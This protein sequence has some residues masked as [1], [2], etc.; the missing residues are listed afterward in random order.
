MTSCVNSLRHWWQTCRGKGGRGAGAAGGNRGEDNE[1]KGIVYCV[2]GQG[3]G[4]A[5]VTGGERGKVR[6]YYAMKSK[7]YDKLR[8]FL[9]LLVA[10]VQG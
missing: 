3:G 6:G 1:G 7:D 9:A 8:P 2:R 5:G 4:K 10:D